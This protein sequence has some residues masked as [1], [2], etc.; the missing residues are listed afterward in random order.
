MN[1]VGA[2]I[3]FS[4]R[5]KTNA[6]TVWRDREL[7]VLRKLD[8]ADRNATLR[9]SG[10]FADVIAIDAP[11]LP[12]GTDENLM[13]RCER[14]FS[15]GSFQTRCKPGM[16]H[17]RGTGQQLRQHGSMAAEHASLVRRMHTTLDFPRTIDRGNVVEAFP[18]TFLGVVIADSD[19]LM[20]P[21]RRGRKFD[22][23]YDIWVKRG[24]FGHVVSKALL[25]ESVAVACDEEKDH[26]GRAA[27][28]CLLTAAFVGTESYVAVGHEECGW[29]FLPPLSLWSAW[30]SDELEAQRLQ[31]TEV[32][33]ATKGS[34]WPLGSPRP[35]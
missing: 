14:L 12:P 33:V 1:L 11:L 2:D 29:F 6:I 19:Y 7:T 8:V 23:L 16:S 34:P 3:G 20:T 27:L 35:S 26:D 18:N 10:T 30:A 28:I 32:H 5:R 13:R 25:P 15:R 24:L 21:P 17:I 4:K 9:D 31:L 22:S